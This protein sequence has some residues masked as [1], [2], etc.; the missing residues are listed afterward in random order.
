MEQSIFYYRKYGKFA[1]SCDGSKL[2]IPP[3]CSSQQSFFCFAIFDL[4][5]DKVCM[6][7]LCNIFV[8]ISEFYDFNIDAKVSWHGFFAF[9]NISK[10]LQHQC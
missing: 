4:I 3:D 9:A 10:V 5:K 1:D 7:S 2:N 8:L 6:R